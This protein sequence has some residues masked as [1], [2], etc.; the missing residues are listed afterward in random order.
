MNKLILCLCFFVLPVL[1]DYLDEQDLY[2]PNKDCKIHYLTS[3]QKSLWTIDVDKSY[4]KDGTINGFTAVTIKDSLN[5]PI[6]TLK[7][8]FHQGYWLSDFTNPINEYYRFSPDDNV[9]DFIYKTGQ[10]QDLRLTYYLVA[11]A[12]RE[13]GQNYPAFISCSE[14]PILLVA[15]EPTADFKK[16]LFQNAVLKATQTHL[17]QLCPKAHQLQILGLSPSQLN[18]ENSLFQ[19]NVNFEQEAVTINYTEPVNKDAIPKPTELRHENGENILTIRPAEKGQISSS[20]INGEEKTLSPTK[21]PK[22]K[23]REDLKSAVDLALVSKIT[24]TEIDGKTIVFVDHINEHQMGVITIPLTLL[25]RTQTAISPG[26]Y[27]IQGKFSYDGE[28]T[29]IQLTSAEPCQKEWCFD[30]N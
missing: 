8:F 2:T 24:G 17:L 21:E 12:K 15:H 29:I 26:W 27:I 11:R 28:N 1:A 7:G 14:T 20:Y 18:T 23:K 10:D 30:E 6:E 19:A 22:I 16:S 5:R 4:C 25:I 13:D 9:Q 3:K